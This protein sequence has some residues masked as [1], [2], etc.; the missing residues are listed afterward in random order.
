MFDFSEPHEFDISDS[1]ERDQ[2][3]YERKNKDNIKIEIMNC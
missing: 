2:T 3:E 1:F